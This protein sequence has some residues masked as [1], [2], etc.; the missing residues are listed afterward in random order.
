MPRIKPSFLPHIALS[1]AISASVLGAATGA[2]AEVNANAQALP[3]IQTD[4]ADDQTVFTLTLLADEIMLALQAPLPHATARYELQ[5]DGGVAIDL[6]GPVLE[7]EAQRNAYVAEQLR[8]LEAELDA[9]ESRGPQRLDRAVSRLEPVL[10]TLAQALFARA[11]QR[12]A[13]DHRTGIRAVAAAR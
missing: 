10:R 8:A 9:I 3:A 11:E 7:T 6:D 4:R 1:V 12:D 5:A 2:Q 13:A